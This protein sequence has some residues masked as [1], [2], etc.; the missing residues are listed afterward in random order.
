MEKSGLGNYRFPNLPDIIIHLDD[1]AD[2]IQEGDWVEVG[3]V[4]GYVPGKYG[5][6]K[7][8]RHICIW[9][10]WEGQGAINPYPIW[11]RFLKI[12]K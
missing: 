9:H 3:E 12:S 4:I 11:F 7:I 5:N 6:A 2:Q 8:P 10:L 1:Y